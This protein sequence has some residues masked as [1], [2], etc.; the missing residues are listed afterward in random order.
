MKPRSTDST[1]VR[2]DGR[3]ALRASYAKA[4]NLAGVLP[5]KGAL[6]KEVV[7]IGAH[8][9][10]LGYGGAGSMKPNVRAIHHGADDNASGTAAVLLAARS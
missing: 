7:V 3:V 2:V 8:Y 4:A 10:H 6:A 1:G 9:D 5:G